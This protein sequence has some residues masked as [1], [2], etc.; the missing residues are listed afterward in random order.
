MLKKNTIP[1]VVIALLLIAC[2][3]SYSADNVITNFYYYEGKQFHL[4]L[5]FDKIFF[6]VGNK[7]SKG[8]F[9]NLL[10]A[11]RSLFDL[12]NYNSEEAA[13]IVKLNTARSEAAIIELIQNLKQ[14]GHFECVSPVFSMPEGQGN[15]KV[16][17]G[18]QNEIIVQF[19]PQLSD[20]EINDFLKER[21]LQIY[22][23]LDLSGGKSFALKVRSNLSSLEVANSVFESS[24]V[25]YSEPNFF[26]T[27]LLNYT[28]NDQFIGS[29]WSVKNSRTNIPDGIL[30]TYDCDM[31]VDSAWNISLGS[32]QVRVSIVDT[33][34]DTLHPDLMNNIV[35]GK[36]YNFF[37]NNSNTM[38]N[39][40]HGTSCAGI[41]AAEGNNNLGVS[42]IAPNAKMFAL[43]IFSGGSTTDLAITN[44]LIYARTSGSWVSSNSWGGG[45][46]ISAA[47][48]AILDGVTLGRGGKGV[49]FCFATGNSGTNSI[50]WPASNSNVI[51]VGGVSPCN[52]R[53]SFSSCDGENYW[54]AEYGT[55]LTVVAPS[56]KIYTTDIRG[57]GGYTSTDYISSFNGTSSATPNVSGVC[58]LA[59]GLDSNMRWDTLRSRVARLADKVGSYSYT[60][61]GYL[62]LGQWNSEMGYG[63]VNAYNL[64][65]YVLSQKGNVTLCEDFTPAAI[66][67]TGW[68][69]EYA[70][71]NF[72]TR[73]SVS[74]Y[75]SGSG[76][77]KF[78]FAN[79]LYG[80]VQA[81]STYTFSPAGAGTYLTF[82]LAYAPWSPSYGPDTLLIETSID[83]GN[84]YSTLKLMLGKADGTGELNTAPAIASEFTPIA[85]Q[86]RPRIFFLPVG[87]NKIR[88]KA[89][90]GFGNNLY[91]D[92]ICVQALPNAIGNTLGVVPEGMYTLDYPH[93][94]MYDT[95]TVYLART[96][97]P[98]VFVDSAKDIIFDNAVVINLLFNRALTG[99][100]YKVVKHRNC[101]ETWS[102]ADGE[103][104]LRGANFHF[105]FINPPGMAYDNNQK[106][107][108]FYDWAMFS[109][110]VNHDHTIDIADMAIIDNAVTAYLT[111]YVTADL[112][113]NNFVDISDYA[114]CDNN[115][116]DYVSRHA[117]PGAVLSA[118]LPVYDSQSNNSQVIYEN[119]FVRQK[120]ESGKNQIMELKSKTET[121]PKQEISK[122]LMEFWK[123]RIENSPKGKIK[124]HDN[125]KNKPSNGENRTGT[126][127]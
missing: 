95:V 100:Y 28:P 56:T 54:A 6:K 124:L 122:E 20:K 88:F 112:T 47:N 107:V 77:A 99:T 42:G 34:I 72:W 48:T 78:D 71:T 17:I 103:Y 45:P 62:G 85:S 51:A 60:L 96:D 65:K 63:K 120:F 127:R 73:N 22:Q 67:P 23:K 15:P 37:D 80:T 66:P 89:K 52:Q 102:K 90:S 46:P 86:W 70:G 9:S 50:Y 94:T 110:D 5:N 13:Q 101:I 117:P 58:A 108:S 123:K 81:L 35:I 25:N 104:Y 83:E 38:D 7:V 16:E 55:G 40:S 26:Q 119:E 116:A 11:N 29:Q 18:Y 121:P 125:F 92:N 19:K 10:G 97:Y 82:D 39:G 106:Q 8:A 75:G 105:N 53:K 64:L 44:A 43:K 87:T 61:P 2:T 33:G 49:V 76:S 4:I 69:E 1:F 31:D 36:G 115:A 27:N 126:P 68:N 98:N 14:S 24:K 74:A 109:G 93:V 3:Q 113:G 30:G 79:A 84:T 91:L 32:S 118:P 41:V 59:L 57:A 114:I 111:G 21:D 12:T